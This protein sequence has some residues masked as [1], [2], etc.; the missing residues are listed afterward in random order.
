MVAVIRY[1][2]V[3]LVAVCTLGCAAGA[4]TSGRVV[5]TDDTSVSF[6]P[7]DRTLIADYFKSTGLPPGLAKY[8]TGLPSGLGKRD[9]L[10]FG[11]SGARLPR[12]LEQKLSPLPANYVRIRIGRDVILMHA[13]TRVIADVI[14]GV[15]RESGAKAVWLSYEFSTQRRK[16]AE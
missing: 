10:P 4:A 1:A 5:L 13:R 15:G 6:T 8:G 3:W 12:E 7:V 11:L 2:I 16:G 9:K 14:H